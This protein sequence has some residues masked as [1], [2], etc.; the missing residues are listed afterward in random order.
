MGKR[1]EG[2]KGGLSVNLKAQVWQKGKHPESGTANVDSQLWRPCAWCNP[3]TTPPCLTT[4]PCQ[5]EWY[6]ITV[7]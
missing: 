6:G 3:H 2:E 4:T 5:N 7:L 1:Q